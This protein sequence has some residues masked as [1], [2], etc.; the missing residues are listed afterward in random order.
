L[1]KTVTNEN[2]IREEIKRRLNSGNIC[3]Y[4]VQNLLY[5][6][7]LSRNL[8]IRIYET[9]ILPVVLYGCETLSLTLGEEEEL[10]V[11]ENV[12]QKRIFGPTSD[13]VTGGWRKLHNKELR[14][15]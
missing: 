3:Y 13:D 5:S 9:K 2:L 6:R 11:F 15:M 12:V 1:W 14:Q 4:S 8:K 7:L 10:K